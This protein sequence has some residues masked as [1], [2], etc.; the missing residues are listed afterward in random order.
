VPYGSIEANAL[1]RRH[2]VIIPT[3]SR[4]SAAPRYGKYLA[5]TPISG[6]TRHSAPAGLGHQ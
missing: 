5:Q 6:S 1:A 2:A 3:M 4:T